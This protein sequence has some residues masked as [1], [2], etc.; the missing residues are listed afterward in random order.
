MDNPRIAAIR[1]SLKVNFDETRDLLDRLSADDL[2]RRAA[3]GWTVA[4]LAGHVAVAPSSA[5]YVLS[6]LRRG[7]N[8]TVP[9]F[10]S[11]APA[12]RNWFI[13]RRYNG[14]TTGDMLKTAQGA[15]DEV[16]AWLGT[17]ADGELDREGEVFGSGRQTLAGFLGYILEHGREH[18][19]EIEAA[20]R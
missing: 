2:K 4:Q 7:G 13:V 10:M 8:A 16:T 12:L 19:T 11:W 5:I 17:V 20:L 18:R 3:N 1:D 15:L 9:A 6:R 14:A